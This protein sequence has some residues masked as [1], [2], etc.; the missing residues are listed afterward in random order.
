MTENMVYV[1]MDNHRDQLWTMTVF[2]YRCAAI[3]KMKEIL[4]AY[5]D[6][7]LPCPRLRV[8]PALFDEKMKDD[9]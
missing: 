9:T 6:L 2:R 4:T 1:I 7:N 8:E 3:Q 5:R